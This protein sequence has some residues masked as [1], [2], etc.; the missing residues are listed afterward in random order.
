MRLPHD[1]RMWTISELRKELGPE[2][3][4]L[5]DVEVE[6]VRACILH[7]ARALHEYVMR[8][9]RG[10]EKWPDSPRWRPPG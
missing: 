10:E 9:R 1:C 7:V 2:A 3:E 4:A 6:R 8:L 5:S